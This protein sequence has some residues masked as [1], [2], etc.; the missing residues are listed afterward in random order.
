MIS[1][2]FDGGFDSPTS[3]DANL[4]V[5]ESSASKGGAYLNLYED[6]QRALVWLSPEQTVILRDTLDKIIGDRRQ[7][8]LAAVLELDPRTARQEWKLDLL[9][10][11]YDYADDAHEALHIAMWLEE[12]A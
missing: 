12:D 9:R 3:N 1:F 5:G 4:I 6:R 8:K 11:A 7:G 2:E 10:K